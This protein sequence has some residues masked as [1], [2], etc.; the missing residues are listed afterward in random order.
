M[1]IALDE[2][3]PVVAYPHLPENTHPA[4]EGKD[5]AIDQVVIG[6]CTNGR[7]ED[8]VSA[9]RILKGRKVDPRVRCIIIPATQEIYKRAMD[10]GLLDIFIDAGAAVS[11]PTCGPFLPGRLAWGSWCFR[12]R[13]SPPTPEFRGCGVSCG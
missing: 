2:L 13:V 6:S 1:T 3:V 5:I 8:L 10:N 4:A 7:Y 12:E 11:T 9:A